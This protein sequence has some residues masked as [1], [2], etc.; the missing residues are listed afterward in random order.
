MENGTIRCRYREDSDTRARLDSATDLEDLSPVLIE[1]ID[2][3]LR[4]TDV[5]RKYL[6][7]QTRRLRALKEHI[8]RFKNDPTDDTSNSP[9]KRRSTRRK[10]SRK[11]WDTGFVDLNSKKIC[12]GDKVEITTV[13]KYNS[14]YG[15]ITEAK[16]S[17]LEIRDQNGWTIT[18]APRSLVVKE[19][20]SDEVH[21]DNSMND[22][23]YWG[24]TSEVEYHEEY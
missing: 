14:K 23:E 17:R 20:D 4:N 9:P 19:E 22:E 11:T 13:G 5:L 16:E 1:Q 15:T 12:I 21:S 2:K 7:N 24:I 8:E 10:S 18:R 3:M 6:G